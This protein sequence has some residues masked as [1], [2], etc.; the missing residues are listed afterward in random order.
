MQ[1]TDKLNAMQSWLEEKN[2][3][4]IQ[5]IDISDI[6]SDM[7]AFIIS[8]A[9][10]DRQARAAADFFEEKADQ[11][12]YKRLGTEGYDSGKWILMDYQDVIVHIFLEEER[13][14]YNLE[15]LWADGKI[16]KPEN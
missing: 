7:D 2:L 16:L 3:Q 10:N 15:K 5:V 4:D 9:A 6:S 1:N 11:N 8:T 14:R 12:G 13:S